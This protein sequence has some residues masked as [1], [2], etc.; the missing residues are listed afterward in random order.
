MST[1]WNPQKPTHTH[2]HTHTHTGNPCQVKKQIGTICL[3]LISFFISPTFATEINNPATCDSGTLST[4]TGPTNLRANYES[5][6]LNLTWYDENNNQLTTNTCSYG[7]SINLPAPP[8]KRGYTFKGWKVVTCVSELDRSIQGTVYAHKTNDGSSSSNANSYGITENGTW[9]V[10]FS[11]GVVKGEALCSASSDHHN[12]YHVN[13]PSGG[14]GGVCSCRVTSYTPSG[15][16]QCNYTGPWT[17]LG[18]YT[19]EQCRSWCSGGCG[20]Y[21]MAA[22]G[23][24][25]D[26][27]YSYK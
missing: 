16:Q 22:D 24:F 9:A 11:Y 7:G 5:N 26:A 1:R 4:D 27:L 13:H 6:Q 21:V 23:T 14:N 10:Q 19:V 2:T 3:I 18:S 20:Y 17:Y 12:T 15:G 8:E 25:R